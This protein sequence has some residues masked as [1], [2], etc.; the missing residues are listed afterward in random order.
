MNRLDDLSAEFIGASCSVPVFGGSF[1][2]GVPK[3]LCAIHSP[4]CSGFSEN[5]RS[6]GST[7]AVSLEMSIWFNCV[8]SEQLHAWC[9]GTL[10]RELD[11]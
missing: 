8:R 2:I 10:S 11:P 9:S 7:G 5:S 1:G 6:S 3:P 4:V